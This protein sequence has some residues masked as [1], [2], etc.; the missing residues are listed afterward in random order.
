[1]A[2]Y[3]EHCYRPFDHQDGRVI[4]KEVQYRC[5][6]GTEMRSLAKKYPR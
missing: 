1:M 3:C 6:Y 5:G 4:L 2:A